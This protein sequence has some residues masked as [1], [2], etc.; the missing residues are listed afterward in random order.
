MH[1]VTAVSYLD[2]FRL[3]VRFEDNSSKVV[4]LGPHLDGPVFEPL[5]DPEYFRKVEVN[6]DIDTITWPN[7]A[8][9]SPE[10]LYEIGQPDG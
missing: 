7:H 2:G 1:Y 3:K 8:D 4:D 6:H 9:F 10:F 5:K